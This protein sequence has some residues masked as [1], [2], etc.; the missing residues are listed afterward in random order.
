MTVPRIQASRPPWSRLA[1]VCLLVAVG[2]AHLPPDVP[3]SDIPSGGRLAV[4]DGW[5]AGTTRG[6]APGPPVVFVHG[7]GGNYHFFDRQLAGVEDRARVIAYDLRGCG[8]SSLAPRKK[9]DLDTLVHDLAVILDVT[10]ADQAILVGHSFGADVVSR[11]AGLHPERVAALVLIDPPGDLRTELAALTA[12]LSAAD[13]AT[14]R[15]R[16]DALTERLL[17]GARPETRTAVL[18]SVRQTPRDVLQ[19]TIAGMGAFE[20]VSALAA[21]QGPLRCVVTD[22]TASRD[23][24]ARPCRTVV[25]L[26]G[27]SHWPMLDEPDRVTQLVESAIPPQR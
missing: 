11:Y 8:D 21:Y 22:H 19:R 7:L 5:L 17:T 9:Y 15:A 3:D 4:A 18:A 10:R 26:H 27:V 6:T 25:H 16:V 13:N 14:F 1:R 12:E 24:A 20:P 2:C 23:P